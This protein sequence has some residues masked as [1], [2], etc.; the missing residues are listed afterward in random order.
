MAGL[1][2]R[3]IFVSDVHLGARD[4]H[5]EY[6]L[7]LLAHAESQYLYL[8]GDIF[9]L[10]KLRSGWCWPSVNNRVV[11]AVLRKAEHGTRVVYIPG[12][13]DELA[14]D[15]AG[16]TF[17]GVKVMRDAVH[18]TCDGR[19][20]LV[21][22]G[23]EFD[24]VVTVSPW[25]RCFGDINYTVLLFLN[26]YY[27][28]LRRG[29]GLPYWSLCSHIKGRVGNAM[30]YVRRFE[31]AAVD[32][33]RHLGLDGIVCGHIHV[34]NVAMIEGRLYANCG[35][36]VES[37]TAVV[38]EGDGVLRLLRWARDSAFLVG[39]SDREGIAD[40]ILGAAFSRLVGR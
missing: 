19:R 32:R 13:H 39:A 38:E 26:H 37:C 24:A 21:S 23:D 3:S 40:G 20:L 25:L 35:D 6:L 36:W 15:Y 27:N 17:S 10:W 34:A 29:V 1:K 28:R 9:D 12:N 4:S 5:A 7:D 14:R 16:M 33:A 18:T 8:V 31:Q 22:H 11:Q 30:A 2:F